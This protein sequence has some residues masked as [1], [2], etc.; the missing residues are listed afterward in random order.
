M[1]ETL[2]KEIPIGEFYQSLNGN[3]CFKI[4]SEYAAYIGNKDMS[5]ADKTEYVSSNSNVRVNKLSKRYII[6]FL[7]GDK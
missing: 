4:S 2:E 6:K 3:I 7:K 5:R 1:K